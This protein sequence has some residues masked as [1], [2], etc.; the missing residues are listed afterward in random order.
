MSLDDA[1]AKIEDLCRRIVVRQVTSE[2]A[3]RTYERI[4]NE[5]AGVE[6]EKGRSALLALAHH[7]VALD[8]LNQ[9]RPG[10]TVNLKRPETP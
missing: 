6:P 1:R 10:A 9:L 4:E 7:V 8:R 3:M 5:Y 2:Q